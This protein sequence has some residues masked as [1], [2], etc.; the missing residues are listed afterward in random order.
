MTRKGNSLDDSIFEIKSSF[1]KSSS[2]PPAS[3]TESSG[4]VFLSSDGENGTS[5][6]RKPGK[7]PAVLLQTPTSEVE[8][9]DDGKKADF[10]R[11]KSSAESPLLTME[12]KN[13]SKIERKKHISNQLKANA[14]FHK[15]FLDVSIDEPLKQSFTCALQK[16]IL[17]QGKLFLSENWICFHS[18]VFG[19]DTKISIPVLSVTLLKKTKTALLVPNA[20]IIATVTDRYMFVSLLSRDTT[21]KL[22]KSICRHLEDTS[23]GNSTNPSSVESSF[24]ADRP[25]TLSLDF[26]EDYSDLDGIVQEQR[27]EMEESSS[28]GSQTPELER[29][30]DYHVVETETHLKVSKTETKSVHSDARSKWVPEGKARNCLRNG[31]SEPFRFFHKV[32]FQ[33]LLSL[34]HIL[35]FY[36]VL[37]CVLILSTFYMRYKINVLEE[38]L[39]SIA[40]FDSHVKEHPVHQRLESHL[41]I[42]ADAF[43]DELTANLIKLE[44]IQNNLQKL[45][46]DDE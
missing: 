19:K 6:R 15:L 32:K 17:Y 39:I 12:S 21:Y 37:V 5:E 10:P 9:F 25:T 16:E 31:H 4:I 11:T 41:Q 2:N 22:L 24:R 14:H 45:L 34:N 1:Q 8:H 33:K 42:N 7:S 44:K 38:R 40:S 3:P 27:Q 36:A 46:E 18:K 26:N 13:D 20:L 23:M 30:Q 29:F 35:I 28:T 43:C